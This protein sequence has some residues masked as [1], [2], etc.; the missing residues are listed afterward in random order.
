M[1]FCLN[2][3]CFSGQSEIQAEIHFQKLTR[4]WY[5][6]LCVRRLC[7]SLLFHEKKKIGSTISVY[8]QPPNLATRFLGFI[9]FLWMLFSIICESLSVRFRRC[10]GN[11]IMLLTKA[12]KKKFIIPDFSE[13]THHIDRMYD[14]ALQ[15]EAG[16]VSGCCSRGEFVG[17][18][19]PR[20]IV[21][22]RCRS[23]A[24]GRLHPAAGQV[25]PWSLGS[26]SV[27]HWR[28]EVWRCRPKNS[29]H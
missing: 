9:L 4:R 18:S 28:T 22:S 13:F 5:D 8:L 7:L 21:C 11:N 10:V 25:Q 20:L 2:V 23:A 3:S 19:R 14:V 6:H 27:H 24:G 26:L 12:F 29:G 1:L 16:Q 17:S 15:H